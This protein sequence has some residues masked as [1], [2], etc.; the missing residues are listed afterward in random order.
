MAINP[1][2]LEWG[3]RTFIDGNSEDQKAN[4][5]L[6]FTSGGQDYTFI[7]TSVVNTGVDAGENNYVLPW[8]LSKDNIGELGKNSQYIDLAG[9]SWYGDYLKD[10]IGAST[11]GFL[12]PT[13]TLPFDSKFSTTKQPVKGIAQTEDGP[14]YILEPPKGKSAQYVKANGNVTTITPGRSILG[15]TLGGFG[16]DLA[17]A[18]NDALSSVNELGPW[19]NAAIA[20][21]SPPTAAVIASANAG[22]AA[23]EGDWEKAALNAGKAALLANAGDGLLGPSGNQAPVVDAGA[24]PS[25][26]ISAEDIAAANAS[27]DP[28]AY[29]NAS[30]EWTLSDPAYLASIGATHEMIAMNTPVELTAEQTLAQ[31]E[32]DQAA[33]MAGREL[34][35]EETLAQ[36]E[37][38]QAASAAAS[39]ATPAQAAAGMSLL[40][41]AKAG[42]LVN[43]IAGDPLGL[44][45]ETGGSAAPTGFAQVSIPAEW[46]SPTYAAPSAPIDLSSIFSNQNMLGGTQWQGLP[47]QQPNISFND[48]FASGQQQ[49]PMG[50]PVDINQIVS[51]ILGQTATSQ[52]PA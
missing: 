41:Y 17:G 15:K 31:I 36:I 38:D 20:I 13:G 9:Q 11:T 46:K 23:G 3:Y 1:N 45:G 10:N 34:T 16:D 5:S 51:S 22:Q 30:K 19:V 39:A 8:F 26:S 24:A 35:A 14:A 28:I 12:V 43:S 37:A 42:L 44:G 33:S 49:T 47:T 50:A 21:A 27:S 25:S 4:Y 18:F 2:T 40:D 52:K 32:A 48:I 6:N 29:L 7:P